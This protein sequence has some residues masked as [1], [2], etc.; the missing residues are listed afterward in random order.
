MK[1][2]QL[3]HKRFEQDSQIDYLDE[4]RRRAEASRRIEIGLR[5]S[6]SASDQDI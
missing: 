1:Y 3:V 4:T 6:A 2:S 5:I